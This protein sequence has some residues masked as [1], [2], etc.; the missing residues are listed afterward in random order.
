M[1]TPPNPPLPPLPPLEPP[2]PH[3]G[4]PI[5]VTVTDV[6]DQEVDPRQKSKLS[7]LGVED[8]NIISDIII[9]ALFALAKI[10]EPLI[11]VAA[12]VFDAFLTGLSEFFFAAQGQRDLGFYTLCAAL[13]KDL[14]GIEV[15]G[16]QLAADFKNNGRL[17]A[18]Q[19]LGGGLIN[20]LASEFAGVPQSTGPTAFVIEPGKGI[21]GLPDKPLTPEGGMDAARALMGFMT[22]FAIREGNT[23]ILADYLP[24][25]IGRWFK[26]FAEDFSKNVG[27]GRLARVA[28]RPLF[29]IMVGT[30]MTWAINKQYRP[31]LLSPAEAV[32]AYNGQQITHD[33]FVEELARHGYDSNRATALLNQRERNLNTKELQLLR[34]L[35]RMNDQDVLNHLQRQ[36]YDL[37]DAT[38][39]M[40]VWD[41]ELARESSIKAADKFIQ[42]YLAGDLTGAELDLALTNTSQ[43]QSGALLL[44]DAE[45]STLRGIAFDL[46]AFPRRRISA[47]QMLVALE[48][49]T[50]DIL[51]YE[52]YLRQR[53][54]PQDDIDILGIDALIL[55]KQKEAAAAKKAAKTKTTTP[56]APPTAPPT[57]P[58]T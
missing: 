52:D 9:A 55:V 58:T 35:G 15:D 40:V 53:G 16:A 39:I 31:T 19:D 20:A 24:Y 11:R 44:S 18:M 46:K 32:R 28:F 54:Y 51:A 43:G 30:P 4:P 3:V 38:N 10:V 12:S 2:P 8:S 5:T 25:G 21:G 1:S 17:K 50:V 57:A 27:I 48:N 47:A 29:Q 22:S 26:D 56:P 41:F 6:T 13:M 14:T 33:Q 7:S 37:F 42:S 36:G 23:D 34:L 49:Q 45:V